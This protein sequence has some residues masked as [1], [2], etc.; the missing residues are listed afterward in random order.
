MDDEHDGARN[1][2]MGNLETAS[3]AHGENG[4]TSKSLHGCSSL[5][6]NND[7]ESSDEG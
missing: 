7:K 1:G 5:G 4:K 2:S 3:S 6:R